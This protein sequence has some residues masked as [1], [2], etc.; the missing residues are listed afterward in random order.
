MAEYENMTVEELETEVRN[1]HIS[2]SYALE[3]IEQ[4]LIRRGI[5]PE[6][7]LVKPPEIYRLYVK[8]NR[9]LEDGRVYLEGEFIEPSPI[10]AF[11]LLAEFPDIFEDVDNAD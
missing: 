2:K 8:Q 9:T 6:G 1:L 7:T 10:E 4:K 11:H 3:L 5:A